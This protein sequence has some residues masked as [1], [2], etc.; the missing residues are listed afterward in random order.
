MKTQQ[1]LRVFLVCGFACTWLGVNAEVNAR[2][3]QVTLKTMAA[4]QVPFIENQG[5]VTNPDVE[6]YAHMFAGTLFVT[7]EKQLVYALPQVNRGEQSAS[8]SFRESFIGRQPT[9]VRGNEPSSVRVSH[10]KGEDP[11]TWSPRLN[12][13]DSVDLGEL[14]QGIRVT[15]KASGNNVEK[16]FHIAPGGDADAIDIAIDGVESLAVNSHDQL[17]LATSIGDIVFTAPFAYQEFDGAR[18]PVDVAYKLGADHHY[19]FTLGH[20][21]H[22]RLLVIDPLLASTYLGGHNP[23]PPGNY[24]DDI[25]YAMVTAGDDVYVAGVTQSPDFPVHLGYDETL[26]NAYPDGF[27]TRMSG[28]LSTV[29]ASTYFGTEGFDRV[30]DLAIDDTGMVIVVGQA[31]F[32][33][34]LTDGAYNWNG[35]TS[36][37]GGFVAKFSPDLST[38]AASALV[39]PGDYPSTVAL[40]NGS[41]YFGGATNNPDFPITADAYL[42]SCCSQGAFGIREYDGFAGVLSSDLTTLEAMTY[43]GGRAVSGMSVAPD[44]NVFIT[45]GFDYAVT[46]YLARFDSDLTIRSAYLSYYPGS[47]SG[48][49]RTYFNDVVAGDGFVAATGQTYMN[50]LPATT[51]AFDTDC[52]TDGL[53]D[54]EGP[55]QV[56]KSDG[57]VAIYSD[58]LQ[59]IVALTYLGGSDHEATR[60]IALDAYGDIYVTGETT[61]IDFPTAGDGADLECGNDGQCDPTG[62]LGTP[63]ADGFVVRLSADLSQMVYGTYLG[64]SG[65]DRPG[66]IAVNETGFVYSA[67]YTRS[68]DFPTTDGAFDTSFNGGTSDAFISQIDTGMGPEAGDMIFTDGFETGSMF[69]WSGNS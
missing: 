30:T 55:L 38:L 45:D 18:R 64:G 29:I 56:P 68:A 65:E 5:Q 20:Y 69:H 32:G 21:D 17:V 43:L 19:G 63:T 53:C 25:I 31:G 58:D 23:N 40:G 28:D 2:G 6:Y 9:E 24:D 52:G 33:F 54:G 44:G 39:T 7:G 47:G 49:S 8:W 34:P 41:I 22:E 66:A 11:N 61:S 16:L 67:G 14:Y 12:T 62:A 1:T 4:A 57:F 3:P 46:G 35:M 26:E 27:I 36:A 42:D 13:Y 48:S 37:G 60:S 59:T 15:L 50:D 10:F 51:G